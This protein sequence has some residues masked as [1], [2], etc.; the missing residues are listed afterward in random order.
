MHENMQEGC[1][2]M[3]EY[4]LG[5]YMVSKNLISNE[6]LQD[7]LAKQ[8]QVR[9]KLGTIAVSEGILTLEQ[10]E[11]VNRLQMSCDKRFGD[12][13]IE[14]GYMTEAQ[15]G[16]ILKLQGNPYLVFIQSLVDEGLVE[17]GK[18]EAMVEDFRKENGYGY[19]DMEAIKNDEIEKIIPLYLSGQTEEFGD[20]IGIAVRLI[21]RSIDRFAYIG[22]AAMLGDANNFEVP[23]V[24]QKISGTPIKRVALVEESDGLLEIACI[25][26]REEYPAIDEDAL[27]AAGEFLNCIDGLY[28]SEIGGGADLQPPTYSVD[29]TSVV[30]AKICM[31]PIWVNN[32]QLKLV[33]VK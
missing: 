8:N 1:G 22:K 11:E 10:A 21:R 19:S 31:V 27:D 32:K 16:K 30:G 3:V 33:V 15:L 25:Y 6:Q 14:K 18:V 26:G 2:C 7:T 13:A 28:T 12:I 24:S 23:V 4:I 17:F 9:V 5:S 20:I 29:G